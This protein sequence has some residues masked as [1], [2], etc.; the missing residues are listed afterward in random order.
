MIDVLTR[1]RANQMLVAPSAFGGDAPSE[2]PT[3]EDRPSLTA[4]EQEVLDCLGRG[5][6]VKSIARALGIGIETCRS[7]VKSLHATLGGAGERG[8]PRPRGHGVD[9]P[10]GNGRRRLPAVLL[11]IE[12]DGVGLTADAA[13]PT[14]GD[15][16][17]GHLGL[18][19]V[20]DRVVE[21]GGA[22]SVEDR[23]S[24]GTVLQAI[25]PVETQRVTATP[26]VEETRSPPVTA[27]ATG[28]PE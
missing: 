10:R 9:L 12:D 8:A 28:I 15:A 17:D 11:T 5:M 13:P 7:Y 26:Q 22:V 14:R 6:P 25:V 21:E 3:V 16:G 27:V 23:S 2:E 4:R 20:H 24:G 19:L 18:R 1:L